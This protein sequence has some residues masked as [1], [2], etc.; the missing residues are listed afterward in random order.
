MK[1]DVATFVFHLNLLVE[2]VKIQVVYIW[3]RTVLTASCIIM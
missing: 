3:F 1:I 2:T